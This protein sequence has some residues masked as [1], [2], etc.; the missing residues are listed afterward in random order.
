MCCVPVSLAFW[1]HTS[2]RTLPG[3]GRESA[4]VVW[5]KYG[6]DFDRSSAARFEWAATLLPSDLSLGAQPASDNTAVVATIPK[7]K[8]AMAH[9]ICMEQPPIPILTDAALPSR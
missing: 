5:T 3:A 9:R 6:S 4:V 7:K 1:Y 2:N 8:P